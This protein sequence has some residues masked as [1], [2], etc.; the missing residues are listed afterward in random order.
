MVAIR[1]VSAGQELL[2]DYGDDFW[3]TQAHIRE[4]AEQIGEALALARQEEKQRVSE[5]VIS[6]LLQHV[7]DSS[8]TGSSSSAKNELA[9]VVAKVRMVLDTEPAPPMTGASDARQPPRRPDVAKSDGCASDGEASSSSADETYGAGGIVARRIASPSAKRKRRRP[10]GSLAN[11]K[12]RRDISRRDEGEVAGDTA[13]DGSEADGD[14][15]RVPAAAPEGPAMM[16]PSCADMVAI[17]AFQAH[18]AE[19]FA[20]KP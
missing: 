3:E 7:T 11:G 13:S 15:A 9:S 20:G 4:E 17:P 12:R 18:L 10:R 6:T 14:L 8:A 1:D 5:Q 19:C 16:C 2:T